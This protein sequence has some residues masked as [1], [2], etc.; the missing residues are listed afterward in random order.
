MWTDTTRVVHARKEQRLP[1]DLTDREWE[2]LE[3]FF[4]P[5]SH[6]GRPRKWS[7]RIIVDALFYIRGCNRCKKPVPYALLAPAHKPV[8]AR[9]RRT[10][11]LRNVRPRRSRS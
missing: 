7:T 6:V 1:S 4:A 11:A 2:V 5:P 10:I 9:C 3:P 8:V